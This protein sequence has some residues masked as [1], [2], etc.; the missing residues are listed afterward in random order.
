[1]SGARST[2][3]LVGLLLAIGAAP[4]LGAISARAAESSCAAKPIGYITVATIND[5]PFVTLM[6][7]GHPVI[8]VLDTGAERTVLLPQTAERIGARAPQVEFQ[9]QLRGISGSLSTREIELENFTA[10]A[11]S[12]PWHRLLVAPVTAAKVFTTPF[13]G[14]L[15]DDVLSGFDFDV[16]LPHQRLTF[17]ERG[18]CVTA[19]PWAGPYTAISTGQSRGEHLFF[20]VK[21]NGRDA[22]AIID[23]GAQR[24][25]VAR[26]A[27]NALGITEALLDHDPTMMTYGATA[28]Q[29]KS[30]IHQFQQLQVGA[31]VIPHPQLV[32]SDV[33]LQD[34]AIVLGADFLR[35]AQI[36]VSY[37]S[38]EIFLTNRWPPGRH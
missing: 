34:A 29:L 17:Y 10:G 36:Y 23:S 16:D 35:S 12:I 3:L 28:E 26:W 14:L 24:T 9:Q 38:S 1:M 19:P 5:V 33:K 25:T 8:L 30:H 20:P 13:D 22:P 27:A 7:N 6:A 11:L 37:A 15:G 4:Q 2:A 31:E 18:A 32:V 21:L